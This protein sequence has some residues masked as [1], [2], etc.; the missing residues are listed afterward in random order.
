MPRQKTSK[1]EILRA[2]FQ[3]LREQGADVLNARKIAEQAGCSV[4]PIYSYF[5]GMEELINDLFEEARRYLSRFFTE[6][7]DPKRLFQSAG[8]CHVMFAQEERNLFQFLFLSPYRRVDTFEEFYRSWA[9]KGVVR[10]ISTACGTSETGS[11]HLY[12]SMMLYTHG[13]ACLIAT[14]AAKIPFEDIHAQIDFAFFSFLNQIRKEESG[15]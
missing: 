15:K 10:E 14:G 13:I 3:L 4:Q 9:I 11:E 7:S 2:A 6:H 5:G 1:E 12:M 8:K